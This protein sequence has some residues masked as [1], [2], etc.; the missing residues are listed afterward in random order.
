M[1]KSIVTL[2]L[3]LCMVAS[4]IGC[5]GPGTAT[6]AVEESTS[7]AVSE[8]PAEEV[9]SEEPVVEEVKADEDIK[10]A[11]VNQNQA[12]PVFLDLETGAF[13][14]AEELGIQLE[15]TA[16]PTGD[17]VGQ[18]E[19]IDSLTSAGVD[20]MAIV[21]FD[22]TVV[23]SM[24][25]ALAEGIYMCEINGDIEC[26]GMSFICGTPQYEGGYECGKLALEYLT[27]AEKTYK[28]AMIEG[29]PGAVIF[30]TR[31]E[32]FEA[33]LT[34]AGVNYEVIDVLPCNDDF[35]LSGELVEQC[36][37]AN[38]DMDMWFF[39]GGWPFFLPSESLPE[40]AAWEEDA[41][42]HCITFD[43]FPPMEV[44]FEKELT[45]GAVGQDYYT[46]GQMA[47]EYLYLLVK[48]EELPATDNEFAGVPWF[49]TGVEVCTPENYVEIFAKKRPW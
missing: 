40:F 10:I 35:N 25:A 23:D 16:P 48:G 22:G 41:D 46:M 30:K 2:L 7:D 20:A 24:K 17:A 47:V 14:K 9:V 33:A 42:H 27:D 3:V 18:A 11:I 12:N 45:S 13:E 29:Q 19:L 8:E 49:S 32:G 38:P 34:D 26:E 39:S 44:Y 43:T 31:M 28:I 15:W 21:P 4:L 6:P 1:K 37:I 36:T 5:S